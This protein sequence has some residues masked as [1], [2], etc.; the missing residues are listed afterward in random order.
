MQH[1]KYVLAA[2]A[3]IGLIALSFQALSIYSTSKPPT[4]SFAPAAIEQVIY[5]N[6]VN[7]NVTVA[8]EMT[9]S[10][11]SPTC[12]L[13]SPPCAIA[14]S[15]LYYIT[16]NGWNYRLIFP[17]ATKIPLNHAHIMVTG[18]FVTPSTY[19]ASEWMPVMSFRGDIYVIS[20]SYVSPYI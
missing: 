20:Y 15:P 11:V 3:M 8:G 10:V 19:K 13:S 17:N 5:P 9:S 6:P 7:K 1:T 2:V 14:N 16:V 4:L 18:V 12:A